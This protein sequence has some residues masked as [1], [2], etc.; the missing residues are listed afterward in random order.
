VPIRLAFRADAKGPR[1]SL[2]PTLGFADD[3]R[4]GNLR[5]F[6]QFVREHETGLFNFVA[7]MVGSR[8]DAEDITQDALLRAYRKWN[9]VDPEA[10]AG[11]VN[12]VT[13]SRATWPWIFCGRKSR[14]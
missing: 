8:E 3:P 10:P 13:A 14:A 5:Q 6:S 9:S 7:R 2:L 4:Q 11:Y 1:V 12:G